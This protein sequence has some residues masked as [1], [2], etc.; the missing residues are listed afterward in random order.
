MSIQQKI[1]DLAQRHSNEVVC[2]ATIAA[3]VTTAYAH[4]VDLPVKLHEEGA[5]YMGVAFGLNM[6]AAMG[7]VAMLI[8][9]VYTW[10]AV[11]LGGGLAL[12]TLAGFLW[13]RTVGFPHLE[14]HVGDWDDPHAV[15]AMVAELALIALAVYSS[16]ARV[17]AVLAVVAVAAIVGVT[18]S[19]VE[20]AKRPSPEARATRAR[21]HAAT[22]GGFRFPST[23][24]AASVAPLGDQ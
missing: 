23:R 2:R 20:S 19:V 11:Q 17:R 8:I 14:D 18:T 12:L 4:G 13:S 22:T 6:A 15:V 16:A 3:L 24:P 9:G 10:A 5:G 21:S 1:S 7:L